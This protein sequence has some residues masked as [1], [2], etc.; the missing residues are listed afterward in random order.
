MTTLQDFVEIEHKTIAD[1]RGE[2]K[3]VQFDS[4]FPFIP[5]RIFT[6]SNVPQG[7]HRG[8]HAHRKCHQVIMVVSGALDLELK[9]GLNSQV[10][11]ISRESKL[12][13]IKPGIWVDMDNFTEDCVIIVFASDH[14]QEKD[15]ILN[16]LELHDFNFPVK[17]E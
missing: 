4:G 17:G 12:S 15:Y 9:D 6:I 5:K 8:G 2:L 11:R 7:E 1:E 14:Y 3:V 16:L 10:F 13:W